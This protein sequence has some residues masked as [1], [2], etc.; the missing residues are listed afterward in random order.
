MEV[1]MA[2]RAEAIEVYTDSDWAGCAKTRKNTSGGVM[3][4]GSTRAAESK[5]PINRSPVENHLLIPLLGVDSSPSSGTGSV[6]STG[7]VANILS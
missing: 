1:R 6:T 7:S 4:R 5:I 3:A 2:G